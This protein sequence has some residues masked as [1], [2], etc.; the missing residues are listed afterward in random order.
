[1]PED[2]Y[3][4]MKRHVNS[5]IGISFSG[6]PTAEIAKNV[7]AIQKLVGGGHRDYITI[8]RIGRVPTETTRNVGETRRI[9]M[10]SQE[11]KGTNSHRFYVHASPSPD[12]KH[13]DLSL[14]LVSDPN[15]GVDKG[16]MAILSFKIRMS[17]EQFP[18]VRRIV[19]DNPRRAAK[20]FAEIFHQKYGHKISNEH[21]EHVEEHL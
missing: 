16:R 7:P 13:M 4:V 20:L 18:T 21:F 8:D 2:P 19:K 12:R 1:M 11:L 17:K 6:K 3:Q 14:D 5:A 15:L 9:V 10:A